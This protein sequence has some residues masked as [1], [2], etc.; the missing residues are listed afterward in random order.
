MNVR[1]GIIGVLIFTCSLQSFSQISHP[2]AS[3]FAIVEQEFGL[4][5]IKV[6]Y[7]RPA[8][9][10]RHVFGPQA[11]GQKGL[12]PYGRIWRVGANESTKI[13]VSTDMQV[14]GKH[15]PKGT[16]AL[17]AFPEENSW[18]IAFHTNLSHWGDGRKNYNPNEDLF[19]IKLSLEK[20]SDHQENFLIA[21]DSITHNSAQME[22]TWANT[23]LVIPFEVD[24][25]AQMELEISRQI[26]SN[27][28]AQTY[29]EAARYLREQN[30]DPKR[31]LQYLNHAL[32]IGGDTYY[33]HRVKSLVEA[34]LGDYKSAIVSAQKSM[35]LA[36]QQDKDEFVR[37]N[38][39]NIKLWKTLLK[40]E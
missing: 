3:P 29:Y 7:S 40:D 16:Y 13:T 6:E 28:T 26:E 12:V 4:S 32:R 38:Q 25:H 18:E 8:V 30:R 31:A 36:N 17:Y 27:P 24:T 2:K 9:R 19:R 15:L 22:L 1:L 20:L 33:F 34:A 35:E 5:K 37:M 21:F 39:K 10:G 11:D 14:K 23:R